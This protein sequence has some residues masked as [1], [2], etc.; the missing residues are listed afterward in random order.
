M[1]LKYIDPFE[2]IEK[3]SVTIEIFYGCDSIRLILK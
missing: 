3:E 2:K 1:T